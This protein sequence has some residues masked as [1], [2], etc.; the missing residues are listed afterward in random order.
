MKCIYCGRELTQEDIY[1]RNLIIDN[2]NKVNE[3]FIKEGDI[4]K[5]NNESC[6]YQGHFYT[7]V[8]NDYIFEGYP[9]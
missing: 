2:W 9:C 5:C 6:E 7:Q 4:Y 3:G 8:D 1:G